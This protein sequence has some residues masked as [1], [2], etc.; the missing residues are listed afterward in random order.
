MNWNESSELIA[1]ELHD[2]LDY[3]ELELCS[4]ACEWLPN[5]LKEAALQGM[6]FECDCWCGKER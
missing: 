3:E 5:L 4:S 6:K 1:K 2:K